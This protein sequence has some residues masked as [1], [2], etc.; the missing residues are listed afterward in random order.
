MSRPMIYRRKQAARP[1]RN[2][3]LDDVLALLA[4]DEVDDLDA[5]YWFTRGRPRKEA[6]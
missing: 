5:A 4:G 2:V 1:Y 3:P 6:R